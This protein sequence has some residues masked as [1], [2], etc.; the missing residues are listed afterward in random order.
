MTRETWDWTFTFT[1]DESS[2]PDTLS[3]DVVLLI[4][5]L[6]ATATPLEATHDSRF[7]EEVVR[8][9]RV[10]EDKGYSID[11]IAE[12]AE[13]RPDALRHLQGWEQPGDQPPH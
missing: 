6:R 5:Q 8:L 13:M 1:G 4:E 10:L 12:H 2:T 11:A 9:T 7:I 3:E